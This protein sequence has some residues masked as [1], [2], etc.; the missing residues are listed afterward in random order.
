MNGRYQETNKFKCIG[1]PF[2]FSSEELYEFYN[3]CGF[4]HFIHHFNDHIQYKTKGYF[5]REGI[6]PDRLISEK[7]AMDF[8]EILCVD[9][10]PDWESG[11]KIY[12]SKKGDGIK[13][14]KK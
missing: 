1:L 14:A 2:R 9:D 12:V 11:A 3:D 4:Q 13:S 5:L 6:E 8:S 10:Y 7:E